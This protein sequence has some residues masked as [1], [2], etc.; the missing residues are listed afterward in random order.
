MV[1]GA[2]STNVRTSKSSYHS[3]QVRQKFFHKIGIDSRD[4]SNSFISVAERSVRDL[5]NVPNFHEPLQYNRDEE[6]LW[7]MRLRHWRS[8]TFGT[9]DKKQKSATT[10]QSKQK[11]QVKFH[12]TVAVVPI[13]MRT[14]YS[15]R[16]RSRLWVPARELCENAERNYVE[17]AAE[18]CDWRTVCEEDEM[19]MC[20]E[21][22]ELVHRV[23]VE[24]N[25][26]G[27]GLEW[28]KKPKNVCIQEY[29]G[30]FDD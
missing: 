14:E 13:P 8:V 11:K 7:E 10:K 27:P 20:R 1:L 17:F 2:R 9:D 21:S 19:Y 4:E 30:C 29:I 22:K 24:T 15:Y 16:V 5:R 28:Y 3:Q 26:F 25:E 18:D 12:D 6:K 23:H